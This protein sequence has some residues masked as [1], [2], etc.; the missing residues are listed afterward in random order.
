MAVASLV[1]S[2]LRTLV[3]AVRAAAGV[4]AAVARFREAREVKGM[5][6]ALRQ[7]PLVHFQRLV[8]VERLPQAL[9][10]LQLSAAPGAAE[11]AIPYPAQRSPTQVAVAAEFSRR[12]TP[13]GPAV[14]GVEGPEPMVLTPVP[15]PLR[16]PVAAAAVQEM[17]GSR[18]PA[19]QAF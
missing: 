4:K 8:A 13:E 16:T 11:L 9:Q 12:A 5:L 17:A 6:A 7:L 1:A 18:V 3:T 19:D 14:Q 10:E 2:I 15:P